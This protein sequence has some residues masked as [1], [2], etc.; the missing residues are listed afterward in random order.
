MRFAIEQRHLTDG[1]G[2]P[3]G[4]SDVEFH[5]FDAENLDEAVGLFVGRTQAEV[6][7]TVLKFPGLRAMATIRNPEG[8]YTIQ[9]TPA[10]QDH[11]PL[12]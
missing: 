11:A 3:I 7:G 6:V 2:K 4:R 10:S 1:S 12:R 8:V 9:L 5:L